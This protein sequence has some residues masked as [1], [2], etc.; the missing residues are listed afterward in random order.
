MKSP[1]DTSNTG[2]DRVVAEY[3]AAA[4]YYD[5][6]WSSYVQATTRETVKRIPIR[7]GAR[8]LDVGCGTGE[9]LRQLCA[10]R[11]PL[12]LAGA[13]PSAKMLAVA[14]AK[15]GD[16][17]T[18]KIAYADSL[19]WTNDSFSVVVSCSAFHYMTHPVPA[20]R[21][22]MRV[23]EPGGKLIVT[24]WCD[25]Y[26]ACRLCSL[27]LRLANRGF[28]K[29]YGRDE[30]VRLMDTVGYVETQV[31]RYKINWLWGL[32]TAIATKPQQPT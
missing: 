26:L 18:L 19:P 16:Q 5:K 29:I 9:L 1:R 27:Y 20:L 10:L 2:D 13:D 14:R 28:F 12:F 15:L 21:E 4:S 7:A 32:M 22:M 31:E 6:R 8:L 24:D 30:C 3:S 25:D 11:T 17:A 23:L